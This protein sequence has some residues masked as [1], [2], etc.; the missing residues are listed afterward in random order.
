MNKSEAFVLSLSILIPLITAVVRHR[1]LP[2]SYYPIVYLLALGFLNEIV[3]YFFFYNTSNAVPTNV[4]FLCEFLLFALQF[5][6]WKNILKRNG[7]YRA[8]IISMTALW[9]VENIILQKIVIF[10][11]L[12][13]V[14]YSFILI[15]MAVNQLNWLIVNEKNTIMSN[16]VF[17]ICIAVI[18][19]FSYKVL[20]EVFYYY[21]PQ[22]LIKNN[23]FVLEA[24][25]NVAYNILLAIAILCIPR[26][27]DFIQPLL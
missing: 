12:F 7:P 14:G 22:S 15:L 8:L 18:V 17:I 11:P 13:Q 5:R 10:S 27:R 23:I 3:C 20:A 16:P 19:F 2:V 26:K 24:L 21:A 4:Y 25:L 6:K 1:D 9:F